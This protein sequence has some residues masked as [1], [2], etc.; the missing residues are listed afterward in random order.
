MADPNQL[1]PEQGSTPSEWTAFME[2]SEI[3]LIELKL[4][5]ADLGPWIPQVAK[6]RWD[7]LEV[8]LQDVKKTGFEPITG[9]CKN[10]SN[11]KA[12]MYSFEKMFNRRI[13][14]IENIVQAAAASRSKSSQMSIG[15]AT[16]M[17][18]QRMLE[19]TATYNACNT[20]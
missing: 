19:V 2:M 3:R 11:I 16:R 5:I 13:A 18:R 6:D 15:S 7:M 10:L 12:F 20:I 4:E 14:E 17:A 9:E 1:D 8:L